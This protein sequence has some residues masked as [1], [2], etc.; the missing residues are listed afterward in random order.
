[1]ISEEPN[2]F[3]NDLFLVRADGTG[4]RRLVT[5]IFDDRPAWSPDGMKVAFTGRPNKNTLAVYTIAPDGTGKALAA[6][7]KH[8]ETVSEPTWSPEGNQL[9]Y[10]RGRFA[11]DGI[12]GDL[13]VVNADGVRR[14]VTTPFSSGALVSSPTWAAG[15]LEG[16]KAPPKLRWLSLP[17]KQQVG[18]RPVLAAVFGTGKTAAAPQRADCAPFVVWHLGKRSRSINPCGDVDVLVDLAVAGDRLAWVTAAVSHTELPQYLEVAEPGRTS[19]VISTAEA[20]PET[21]AG[22]YVD[23]LRGD[24]SLLVF[25]FWHENGKGAV[26]NLTT[27]RVLPPGSRSA[28]K[29]PASTGDVAPGFS[30]RRCL[31]LRAGD[32]MALLS[33]SG[34]RIV[35]VKAGGRILVLRGD[36]RVAN[37]GPII[38]PTQFL[39]ARVQDKRLIMLTKDFVIAGS[40]RF[41][42]VTG[43]GLPDPVLLGGFGNFVLY[44]RGAVHLVRLSDGRDVALRAVGQAT[45]VDAQL[46][47]A[48]LFYLYNQLYTRKPGR[49]LFVPFS[50]LNALVKAG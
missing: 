2:S 37:Q 3:R 29:C 45:P 16:G 21:G 6:A 38:N 14:P 34:G 33:V 5:D 32:G 23:T 50:R 18:G 31:R 26:S 11:G 1:F 36:G 35:G 40:K 20:D 19:Q 15:P 47:K 41:R 10:V 25:N 7:G 49:I 27:W 30:R 46:G 8:G 43:M 12:D 9:A 24:G 42:I 48:G 17:K 4:L 22:D 13:F 39:G 44:R 28:E